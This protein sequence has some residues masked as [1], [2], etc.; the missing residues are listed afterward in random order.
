MRQERVEVRSLRL[1]SC[2]PH[3]SPGF[4]TVRHR[5]S[6]VEIAADYRIWEAK[7]P[8]SEDVEMWGESCDIRYGRGFGLQNGSQ[9]VDSIC[10]W[11]LASAGVGFVAFV[12]SREG[13]KFEYF[14][15]LKQGCHRL[16]AKALTLP[17]EDD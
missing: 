16:L 1:T 5:S 14:E 3:I 6:A 17:M 2:A 8:P 4:C 7:D 9:E 12:S 13:D 10:Y 15:A 11:K